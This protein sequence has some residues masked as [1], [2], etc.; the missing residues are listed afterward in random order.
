MPIASSYQGA[1]P[2]LETSSLLYLAA[3]LL[4]LGL[5]ANLL[6]QLIVRR[7]DP[8]REARR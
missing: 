8:L 2:G 6:A 7:F 1:N 3:V 4:V 5:A